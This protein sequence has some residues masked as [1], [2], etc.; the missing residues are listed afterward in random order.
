[1]LVIG[2]FRPSN[3]SGVWILSPDQDLVGPSC[4]CVINS[5]AQENVGHSPRGVQ[6]EQAKSAQSRDSFLFPFIIVLAILVLLPLFLGPRQL[7]GLR[8]I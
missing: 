2:N 8:L 1:M 7:I 6:P 3:S 4:G 5:A